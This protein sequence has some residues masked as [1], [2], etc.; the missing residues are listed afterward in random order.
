MLSYLL[1]ELLLSHMTFR[2]VL[3]NQRWDQDT[4]IQVSSH[5]IQVES[6]IELLGLSQVQVV[7][8]KSKSSR[9]FFHLK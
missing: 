7:P 5:K 1:Y 8:S 6:Q 2:N 9:R 3:S 4:I